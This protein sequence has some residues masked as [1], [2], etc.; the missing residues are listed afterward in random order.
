MQMFPFFYDIFSLGLCT[1]LASAS[2][3]PTTSKKIILS[4]NTGD[5]T[6]HLQ[7]VNGTIFRE[8]PRKIMAQRFVRHGHLEHGHALHVDI[9]GWVW[10]ER[11][12]DDDF[13]S[14]NQCLDL[15]RRQGRGWRRRRRW[16]NRRGRVQMS[17]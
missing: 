9:Q 11:F 1:F 15:E 4:L 16:R 5:R 12:G 13:H 2:E 10:H 7:G 3:P 14:R 17:T 6:A 8:K